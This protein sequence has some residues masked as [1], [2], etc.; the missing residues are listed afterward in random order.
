M[1]S[2]RRRG[3]SASRTETLGDF[4]ITKRSQNLF[5]ADAAK[6]AACSWIVSNNGFLVLDMKLFAQRDEN[7]K[8]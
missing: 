4:H 1:L 2:W 8:P 7:E 3:D 6:T 5:L